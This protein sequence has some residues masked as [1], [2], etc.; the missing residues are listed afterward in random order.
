MLATLLVAIVLFLPG[1]LLSRLAG[2]RENQFC[3]SLT[4]SLA[5]YILALWFVRQ[6][7]GDVSALGVVLVAISGLLAGVLAVYRWR[8]PST[9][10]YIVPSLF[11][12]RLGLGVVVGGA[13]GLGLYHL[14]FGVYDEM[15]SD[16]YQHINFSNFAYHQLSN[17]GFSSQLDSLLNHKRVENPWYVLLA[18]AALVSHTTPNDFY[19]SVMVLTTTAFFTGF[20]AFASRIFAIYDFSWERHQVAAALTLVLV[21]AH[22][23]THA[24][25][26]FRY[27]AYAPTILNFVVFFT[28]VIFL[29]DLLERKGSDI[30][31]IVV[32]LTA[33][34][35]ASLIHLQEGLFIL[36]AGFLLGLW[37]A[38]RLILAARPDNKKVRMLGVG[39]LA[40][41]VLGG[42]SLYLW[43]R[44][45]HSL[46]S[47]NHEKLLTF[48][49]KYIGRIHIL[50]PGYQFLFVLSYWGVWVYCL[51]L[52]FW[53]RL[54]V[55]P[56]LFLGMLSPLLTVFNPR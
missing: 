37:W 17:G 24:F 47:V 42:A 27:Y 36:V 5:I 34:F 7:D 48:S 15:P 1:L 41:L 11:S 28:A 40:G 33:G 54:W 29:L 9:T 55:Q 19:I 16:F 12:H 46:K 53:K 18:W 49:V 14:L 31:S 20:A 13:I 2:Y 56:Y 45:G 8:V 4:F 51:A 3:V 10:G 43:I 6:I 21:F 44:F 25:S 39:I 26:Y 52:I 35:V 32:V 38:F 30:R 50:N 22:F 23:G